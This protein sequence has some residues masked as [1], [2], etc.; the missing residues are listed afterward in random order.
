M[1]P[2][3][4]H[5]LQCM[6]IWQGSRTAER[7]VSTPGLDAWVFSRP[8]EGAARGGDVHYVSL[9][10]GGSITRLV[11]ADVAGHGAVVADV[12]R[13]L[14]RL[15][16]R[17]INRRSPTR[18]ARALNR[19]FTALARADRFAT[20][21]VA[22][23]LTGGR[24]SICNAGHPRPLWYRAAGGGWEVLAGGPEPAAGN[25]PLGVDD[26]TTYSQFAVELGRG[27]VV[28][29]YTDALTE[30]RD[31]ADRLLGEAGLLE[32]AA[33][34]ATPTDPRAFGR[35]LLAAVDAFRGGRPADDDLTALVLYHNAGPARRPGLG[36]TLGVYAKLLGLRS[37]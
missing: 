24:L 15:M 17:N 5:P 32:R 11:V 31:P 37:V 30:A 20:A 35:G 33:G 19:E 18:L 27:D 23:Y 26:G 34:L 13:S 4:P 28:V 1:V 9:C 36:E 14:R 2:S 8:F 12:A 25:L 10:G 29:F 6:E 3:D 7:V 21:V 16:R 22:T